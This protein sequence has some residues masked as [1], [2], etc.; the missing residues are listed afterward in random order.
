M[1]WS[2][3]INLT[4]FV[5]SEGAFEYEDMSG[6][7]WERAQHQWC[8]QQHLPHNPQQWT[9]TVIKGIHNLTREMWMKR[10]AILHGDTSCEQLEICKSNCRK[11]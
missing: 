3:I 2:K 4:L 7:D 8:K 9:I 6:K 11:S 10:N 5:I 1:C